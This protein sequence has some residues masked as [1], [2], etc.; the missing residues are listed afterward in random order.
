V[1]G[2]LDDVSATAFSPD[3]RTLAVL[4]TRNGVGGGSRTSL[5]LWDTATRTR[6]GQPLFEQ[7][8]DPYYTALAYAPDGR[9]LVL[10][11]GKGRPLVIDLDVDAWAKRACELAPSCR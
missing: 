11:T 5:E 9:R 2:G 1:A 6:V 10:A 8:G 3:G 4:G 7:D